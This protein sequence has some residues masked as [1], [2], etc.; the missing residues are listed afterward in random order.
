MYILIFCANKSCYYF[1]AAK[2][3][4][5]NGEP[6]FV[7]KSNHYNRDRTS[8]CA[9][10]SV[11]Y[12]LGLYFYSWHTILPHRSVFRKPF[13]CIGSKCNFSI[14]I[15]LGLFFLS[16]PLISINTT[17]ALEINSPKIINLK[18]LDLLIV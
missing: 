7:W 11:F 16:R 2:H 18:N 10:R 4:W 15:F 3:N 13:Y 5:N 9:N 6:L 17:I 14:I 12:K 1:L 8:K